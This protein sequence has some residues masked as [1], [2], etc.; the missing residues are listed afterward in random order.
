VPHKLKDDTPSLHEALIDSGCAFAALVSWDQCCMST[1]TERLNERYPLLIAGQDP[2]GDWVEN[3]RGLRVWKGQSAWR[4]LHGDVVVAWDLGRP[5]KA[6]NVRFGDV[7]VEINRVLDFGWRRRAT[8]SRRWMYGTI[9]IQQG[10]VL[11]SDGRQPI[12]ESPDRP[13]LE[14]DLAK[15]AAFRV[16]LRDSRFAQAVYL[17]LRNR[18]FR[19]VDADIR[20]RC[21]DRMAARIAAYLGDCGDSYLDY[22]PFCD[23]E[24][25]PPDDRGWLVSRVDE[26]LDGLITGRIGIRGKPQSDT[27]AV[28]QHFKDTKIVNVPHDHFFYGLFVHE[29]V[30][31]DKIF[32]NRDVFDRVHQHITRHGWTRDNNN[33]TPDERFAKLLAIRRRKLDRRVELLKRV[34]ECEDRP[35]GETPDWARPPRCA[36]FLGADT[37]GLGELSDDEREAARGQIAGRICALAATG[38]I[39]EEELVALRRMLR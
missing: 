11:F 31:V 8:G 17:S 13:G 12:Y 38:R 25:A 5:N 1:E 39:S 27:L 7:R 16:E 3:E 20:W 37:E 9:E 24:G 14:F 23:L 35:K 32:A 6:W 15:D 22:F 36:A 18:D 2:P 10:D 30:T 21:G 34:R 26:R 4:T 19:K 28:L 29:K 33:E